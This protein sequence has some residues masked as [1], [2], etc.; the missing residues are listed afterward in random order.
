MK[1]YY[2]RLINV[3]AGTTVEVRLLTHVEA[4]DSNHYYYVNGRD[5]RWILDRR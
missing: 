4:S 2:F 3:A 5:F 1:S